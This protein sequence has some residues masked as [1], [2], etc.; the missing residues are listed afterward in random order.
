MTWRG[1]ARR[2]IPY[3]ITAAGGFVLAYLIVATLIF[4]ARL[5]STDVKVPNVIGLPYDQAAQRLKISG[6][7]AAKGDQRYHASAPEGMVLGQNP[8][9]SATEPKGTTVV[10][11]VS[12]GQR[13]LD[14]PQLVG[15]TRQQA[16][17][18]IE[19]SGLDVGDVT[20]VENPAPRGQV[21]SSAPAAGARVPA[22]S[23]VNLTVSRGPATVAIPDVTGQSLDA[24]RSL[25][26][27]LG[28]KLAPLS[29]DS[30]GLMPPNSIVSQSPAANASVPAGSTVHLTVA[31]GAS[32]P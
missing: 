29:I 21:L 5:V 13:L 26:T 17:L 2:S 24:A 6:F 8:V 15:L 32:A 31:R 1:F 12:R 28:F 10:L 18:A 19:N 23:P 3:L 27:Q 20:E 16:Q 14:V 22:P 11:D 9:P 25:L 7:L 4:P 30:T